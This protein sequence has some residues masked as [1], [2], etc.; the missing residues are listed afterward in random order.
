MSTLASRVALF[1]IVWLLSACTGTRGAPGSDGTTGLQGPQ[2]PAGQAGSVGPAGATGPPGS[3]VTSASLTAG[4]PNCAYGAASFSSTSG[5]TYACN[6]AAGPPGASLNPLQIAQLRW[7]SANTTGAS[8][9]VGAGPAWVAF[10]GTN[11][12]VT[13]NANN[14][15]TKLLASTGATLG[16][17]AVGTTPVEVAFDGANIWVANSGSNNVSRL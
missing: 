3:S 8:F 10:D 14:N 9:A 11:I 16:T 6:G 2:G 1:A 5:M 4:D 15:V 13:N 17:F 12:W 7:F